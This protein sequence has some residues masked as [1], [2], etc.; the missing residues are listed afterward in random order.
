MRVRLAEIVV[1][2]VAVT[3]PV[4]Q[5]SAFGARRLRDEDAGERKAGRVVLNELHVLERR[6]G[7]VSERHAV[8]VLDGGVRREGEHFAAAAGAE[9]DG[10]RR[11]RF[12]SAG[13]QVERDNTLDS[14][15]IDEEP[16]HEPFVV[17]NHAGIFEGSLEE[18]VEHVEAGLVG[19]K[20][21]AHL[22]HATERANGNSSVGLPAPGT[23]PVLEAEELIGRLLDERF[24]GILVAQPVAPGDGVVR[25]LVT[26]VIGANDARRSTLGGDR[27][28]AHR[29]HL[30]HDRDVEAWDWSQ[31]LQWRHAALRRRRRQAPRRGKASRVIA[32]LFRGIKFVDQH[33]AIVPDD[34]WLMLPS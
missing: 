17:P 8:A 4:D 13:L 31:R 34:L 20:P 27:V 18:R 2:E 1:L 9:D 33:A 11:N 29:V 28:A 22:L 21:R 16:G 30:G 14:A 15:V 3:V 26:T 7:A 32:G 6:A 10:A 25:M 5:I 23:A 24:D 19:G 12:D